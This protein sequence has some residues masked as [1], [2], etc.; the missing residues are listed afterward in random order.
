M[1]V[2]VTRLLNV[3]AEFMKYRGKVPYVFGGASPRGW[4]C[5]GAF[6]YILGHDLGMT[7]PGGIKNFTGSWHGPVVV[8]YATWSGAV[9]VK[10]PPQPNDMCI[11]VGVGAAGHMGL[12]ISATH[13]I[14]ALDPQYG[15]AVTPIA[16]FGPPGAPLIYRRIKGVGSDGSVPAAAQGQAAGNVA[17]DLLLGAGVGLASVGLLVGI[18]LGGALLVGGGAVLLAGALAGR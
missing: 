5:S 16:G 18:L 14:S 9:T 1:A 4:D 15:T 3:G 2:K 13:M 17:A 7:L 10:G 12:A 8:Q 11:W 6:N